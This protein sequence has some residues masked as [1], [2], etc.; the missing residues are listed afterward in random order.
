MYALAFSY[1]P[2]THH[3]FNT[4][5]QYSKIQSSF[6]KTF[7]LQATKNPAHSDAKLFI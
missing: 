1:D 2:L 5:N 7:K 4:T 6:G 3:R